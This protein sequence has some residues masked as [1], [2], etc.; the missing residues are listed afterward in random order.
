M[1]QFHNLFRTLIVGEML[2]LMYFPE[3]NQDNGELISM[4]IF[5]M[6]TKNFR[7]NNASKSDALWL[8]EV[9]NREGSQFRTR[10]KWNKDHSMDLEWN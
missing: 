10:V 4:K 7:L 9:L 2:S 3:V 6:R 1:V 5:P 8:K